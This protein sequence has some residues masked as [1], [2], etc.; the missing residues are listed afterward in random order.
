ME[1]KKVK[2][3]LN[4]MVAN[5]SHCIIRMLESCY[6]HIDYWV[7]QD[8]GSKDGTQ[9][10]IRNFFKQKEIPGLLYEIPWQY[11]G[12][13]RDHALQKCLQEPHGCDWILRIDA[14][15][16]LSVDH[17][18]DWK[19]INN[20]KIQSFNITAFQNNCTYR[21]CWLWNSKLP[22]HFKHDK[23]HE[24][25]YMDGMGETFERIDLNQKF[26]HIVLGDGNTWFNP[27]KFYNDALE[28]E[29]DL[30][31]ENK[32][33]EDTYHLFYLAK[34][35]RDAVLDPRSKFQFGEAHSNECARRAIFF[36]EQHLELTHNFIQTQKAK[37]F[38]ECGYMIMIFIGECYKKL[39]DEKKALQYF[40]QA[41]QFCPN[42]NEHL[43]K[44]A[45]I[46]ME[47][48]LKNEFLSTTTR[49]ISS[50][51]TNPYPKLAFFIDNNAYYN[52]GSHVKR[53]HELACTMNNIQSA[54]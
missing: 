39:N 27:Q 44:I 49:L 6:R 20:V 5:E 22:W 23:R 30:L 25:I 31:L 41:E 50:D 9:D 38:D 24:T 2:I 40:S 17:D 47:R 29:R 19:P 16:L 45:E 48:G 10:L 15:E 18:F 4:T 36:F 26:K 8:N 3:C 43:L 14:D 11:P 13:N 1:E 7:I 54:T 37:N 52:T 34:S 28:I 51:R 42:R 32:M 46:Y 35:Y 53:L 12:H 21:R 33:K